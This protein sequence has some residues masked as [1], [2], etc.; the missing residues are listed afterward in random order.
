MHDSKM[1]KEWHTIKSV[2][3]KEMCYADTFQ[4]AIQCA[5]ALFHCRLM[6]ESVARDVARLCRENDEANTSETLS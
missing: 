2:L 1:P 3:V 5:D 4:H 6:G